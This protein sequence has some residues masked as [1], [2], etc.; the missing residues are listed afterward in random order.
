MNS[1][2][3]RQARYER[4]QAKRALAKAKRLEGHDDFETVFSYKNLYSAYRKCRKGVSWKAST[5]RFITQAP[6]E[7][8]KIRQK[9]L[10]GSWRSPGFYEFDIYERGKVR[11]IKSVTMEE[12]VIQ[13]CLCDNAL[14]PV[15][16][17][18]FIYDNGA[19]TK[20]KGYHF[21][22]NRCEKHLHDHYRKY[23]QEGYVLIFDFSKF[24][25]NVS[26]KLCMQITEK[27]FTD[28]RLKALIQHFID[29][30]GPIGLGL[31]SQIS[32]TYALACPSKL[33][34]ALKEVHQIHGYGRYMD[35]GHAID[36]SKEH[37]LYVL[38]CIQRICD[39]LGIKLNTKKTQIIK[40]S[41]GFTY[42][43]CRF[44]LLPDGRVIRKIYKH[45]TTRA[46]NP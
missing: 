6:L 12:R 21:S 25:D 27:A 29:A 43:K 32:Q 16:K 23:G 24:F 26:H 30:F 40:L 2:E 5:Q 1:N 17:P 31:G 18:S 13:R 9:L 3:R 14:V 37:L 38:E 35:D 20:G 34:H 4:R 45:S 7:V 22:I 36:I 41:H 28:P 33:D 10:D 42:L 19:S 46:S 15:L 39:E 44:Y 11:H 8:Y